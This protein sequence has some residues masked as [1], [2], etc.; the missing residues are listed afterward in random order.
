MRYC[1]VAGQQCYYLGILGEL[2][3]SLFSARMV[4]ATARSERLWRT[5]AKNDVTSSLSLISL[6]IGSRISNS[7]SESS[8]KKLRIGTAFSGWNR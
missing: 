1:V 2:H 6:S 3:S 8:S 4:S 7:L 5:G